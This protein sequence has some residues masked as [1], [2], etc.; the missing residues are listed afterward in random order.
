MEILTLLG[1]GAFS[2]YKNWPT[3]GTSAFAAAL[4]LVARTVLHF[5]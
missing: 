4:Y 2:A 3:V 5:F 1:I